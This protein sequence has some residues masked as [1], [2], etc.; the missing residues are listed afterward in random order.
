MAET[1]NLARDTSLLTGALIA[2]L[3]APFVT[4]LVGMLFDSGI[5]FAVAPAIFLITLPTAYVV[6]LTL[7][8]PLAILLRRIGRLTVFFTAGS[9]FL[10]ATAAGFVIY[11]NIFMPSIRQDAWKMALLC[12]VVSLAMAIV[13]CVV[14]GIPW[15]IP[16]K[17]R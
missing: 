9:A 16:K 11:L 17:A 4:I 3:A 13:G 1:P 8:L 6:S 5:S 10:L 12:G 14:A 7:G 15:G 2:P